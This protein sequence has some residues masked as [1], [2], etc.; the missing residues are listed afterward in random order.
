MKSQ[1]PRTI[2]D[3]FMKDAR[4][5]A[6]PWRS[7]VDF[8]FEA[9][10]LYALLVLSEQADVYKHPNARVRVSRILCKRRLS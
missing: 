1:G 8:A 9:V 2:A 4:R 3:S 7:R 10:Y 6:T 5:E